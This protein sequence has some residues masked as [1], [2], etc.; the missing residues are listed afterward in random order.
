MTVIR[1]KTYG[2]C[3]GVRHALQLAQE[4]GTE[5]AR[6]RKKVMSYGPLI[7]NRQATQRLEQSG[8]GILDTAEFDAG[9]LDAQ[10]RDTIVVIRAHGAPPQVFEHLESAGATVVDAT[11]PRVLR[12]QKKARELAGAGY[13]IVVAGD[14]DHAEV[15]GLVGQVPGALVVQNADEAKQFFVRHPELLGK[16][17]GLLAQSTI[18]RS[19]YEAIAEELKCTAKECVVVDTLCP[20]S[21]E[22]QAALTELL[23]QV[24]AIIVVG[25]KNS[26]NTQRLAARVREAGKPCWHIETAAE[27]PPE[28]FSYD[29]IGLTAGASTPDFVVDEVESYLLSKSF[30]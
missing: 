16:K 21:A 29:R 2:M 6:Q 24:S 7:H 4:A 17:L 11:C 9:K 20:A 28:V 26:A 18:Q 10:V 15:A 22:R 3:A 30:A 19:E 14:A 1:A 13:G 5:G 8:I 12:S 27:L 23:E 25:G